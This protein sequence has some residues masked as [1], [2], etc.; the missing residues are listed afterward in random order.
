MLAFVAWAFQT[1]VF[2]FG[3]KEVCG[4]HFPREPSQGVRVSHVVAMT[5]E[6]LETANSPHASEPSPPVSLGSRGNFE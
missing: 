6:P 1:V 4:A 3:K 2:G 5:T